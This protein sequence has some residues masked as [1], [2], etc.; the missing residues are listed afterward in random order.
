MSSRRETNSYTKYADEFSKEFDDSLDFATTDEVLFEGNENSNSR[1]ENISFRAS[2]TNT[3]SSYRPNC[4]PRP[5]TS[6]NKA[7]W[8]NSKAGCG[9]A[10]ASQSPSLTGRG[11]EYQISGTTRTGSYGS[12]PA[13]RAPG[14]I[15]YPHIKHGGNNQNRSSFNLSFTFKTTE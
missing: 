5:S 9:K 8:N 13:G 3:F 7:N 15:K 1:K 4:S 10:V 12:A 6:T 2:S 14:L 11:Q